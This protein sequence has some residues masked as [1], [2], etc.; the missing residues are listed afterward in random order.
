MSHSHD[1]SCCDH[2]HG[3]QTVGGPGPGGPPPMS[4]QI[5][6]R[7][8]MLLDSLPTRMVPYAFVDVPLPGSQPPQTQQMVVCAEHK[9]PVCEPCGV[10]FTSL[11]YM[12]QFMR[13]SPPEA[14]PPPP[15]VQP[16][17]QRAEAIKQAKEAGNVSFS[18]P[19][20]VK[21][22]TDIAR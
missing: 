2:D 10:N 9:A 16:P 7:M 19:T 22:G 11:N 8:Q 17:P 21:R 5:D 15:Q 6:E 13:T 1:G 18:L 3:P 14:I 4:I 12:H 20:T